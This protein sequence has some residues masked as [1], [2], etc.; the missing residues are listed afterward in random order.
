MKTDV[1]RSLSCAIFSFF[2]CLDLNLSVP[3]KAPELSESSDSDD[4]DDEDKDEKG[5]TEGTE[6]PG[7]CVA[8][9]NL[10]YFAFVTSILRRC[11]GTK[12]DTTNRMTLRNLRIREV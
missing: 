6:M 2:P 3:P 10:Q 9:N 12:V 7:L 5:Y 1:C 11:L 4:S 8:I